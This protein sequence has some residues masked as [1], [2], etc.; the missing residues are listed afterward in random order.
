MA[1]YKQADIW[2]CD[3]SALYYNDTGRSSFAPADHI[4]RLVTCDKQRVSSLAYITACGEVPFRPCILDFNFA[5]GSQ[6]GVIKEFKKTYKSQD[7]R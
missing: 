2:N 6:K 3:E 4:G 5:N 7:F 1:G